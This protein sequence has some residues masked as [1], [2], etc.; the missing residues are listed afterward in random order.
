MPTRTKS[1]LANNSSISASVD[2]V[3]TSLGNTR[4]DIEK[5]IKKTSSESSKL[6]K[7]IRRLRKRRFSLLAKKIRTAAANR[8]NPTKSREQVISKITADLK[9]IDESIRTTTADRQTVLHELS[10]LR[11]TQKQVKAY[12]RA[13]AAANKK[14]AQPKRKSTRRKTK[15]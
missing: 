14:L 6:L 12:V 4:K 13:V 11:S 5:T 1:E 8:K 3:I 2:F 10:G 15:K 7:T 9:D